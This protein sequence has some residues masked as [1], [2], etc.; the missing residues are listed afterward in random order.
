MSQLLGLLQDGYCNSKIPTEDCA[1]SGTKNSCWNWIEVYDHSANHDF[2]LVSMWSPHVGA[3][4]H[5]WCLDPKFLRLAGHNL[6]INHPFIKLPSS[7]L[8]YE[9]AWFSKGI[10]NQICWIFPC[11]HLPFGR[12]HP[13][14]RICCSHP[15]PLLEIWSPL[16]RSPLFIAS[17]F[18]T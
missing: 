14:S 15:K 11:S 1:I 18:E 8:A 2:L 13:K 9:K 4:A 5:F 12:F 3:V 10:I 17:K 16:N 6:Q 7:K